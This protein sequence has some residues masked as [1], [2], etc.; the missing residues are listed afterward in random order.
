MAHD[1]GHIGWVE[2]LSIDRSNWQRASCICRRKLLQTVNVR[3][4]TV[5]AIFGCRCGRSWRRFD[6]VQAVMVV[7]MIAVILVAAWLFEVSVPMRH[8]DFPNAMPRPIRMG[9]RRRRRQN[10]KLRQGDRKQPGQELAKRSHRLSVSASFLPLFEEPYG[11][12]GL[13]AF[14]ASRFPQSGRDGGGS[15]LVAM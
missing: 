2:N 12:Y 7:M 4:F 5:A 15:G 1:A 9:M 8:H 11:E 14:V 13:V 6:I 3:V 10:A